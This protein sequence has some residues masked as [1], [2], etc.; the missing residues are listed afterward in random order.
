MIEQLIAEINARW[1]LSEEAAE[2]DVQPQL[3]LEQYLLDGVLEWSVTWDNGD[4]EDQDPQ[5]YGKTL[6]E[7]LENLKRYLEVHV[8]LS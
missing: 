3:K 1:P 7:A 6:G 2:L 4:H 5:A 8:G